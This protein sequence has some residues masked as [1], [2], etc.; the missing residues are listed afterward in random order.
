MDMGRAMTGLPVGFLVSH[1]FDNTARLAELSARGPG[2]VIILHG[3]DDEVIP[4]EMGRSLAA[5]QSKTVRLREIRGGRHN[6][7]LQT[8]TA[9]VAAALREISGDP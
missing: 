9:E 2:K 5:G 7:I 4:V 8:H 1:R 6:T 3:S